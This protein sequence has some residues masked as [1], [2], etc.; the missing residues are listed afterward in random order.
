MATSSWYLKLPHEHSQ[1]STPSKL[2]TNTGTQRS[3]HDLIVPGW[4]SAE[5]I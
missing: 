5:L 2:I 1:G 3:W 4:F